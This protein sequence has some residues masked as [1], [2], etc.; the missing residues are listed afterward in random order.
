MR[1]LEIGIICY[2]AVSCCF[3]LSVI[4]TIMFF[5]TM[6]SGNLMPILLYM[7]VSDFFMN[8]ASTFGFPEDGSFLCWLQGIMQD[9]FALC[10][11]FW[12]TMLAYRVYCFVKYGG[13][14]LNKRQMHIICWGLP[15][16]LT[17]LPMTST[18]YG[19]SESHSQWCVLVRRKPFPKWLIYFWSYM[20]YF[21]WLLLCVLLMII[22]QISVSYRFKESV[23]KNVVVRTYDKVYLYPIAMILCWV[24]DYWCDDLWGAQSVTQNALS[25]VFGISNGV[26]AALIFM[27]KSEEARRRW[28]DYW[29]QKRN[30]F[31][32]SVEPSIRLDFEEDYDSDTEFGTGTDYNTRDTGTEL[33][34]RTSQ[35]Q[36]SVDSTNTDCTDRPP[37]RFF[38]TDYPDPR[39]DL[40]VNENPEFS[41]HVNPML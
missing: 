21:G 20:T 33:N 26:F 17:A 32:E 38:S 2:A 37:P 28:R 14:K 9:Y 4:G 11:W 31:D 18:N 27:F 39:G 10:S 23:M 5:P 7:S 15:L 12:T 16:L 19:S 6:K 1:E 24:L 25:M 35:P 22:W 30:S 41:A 34:T 36:S 29:S 3:S 13:C 8:I 40:A